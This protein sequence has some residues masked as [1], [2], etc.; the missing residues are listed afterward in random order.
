MVFE[1]NFVCSNELKELRKKVISFY[2]GT[3]KRMRKSSS[4]ILNFYCGYFLMSNELG[5]ISIEEYRDIVSELSYITGHFP[6][7]I[8]GELCYYKDLSNSPAKQELHK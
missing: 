8:K 2:D 7:V 6:S 1:K 5:L 4:E 3:H